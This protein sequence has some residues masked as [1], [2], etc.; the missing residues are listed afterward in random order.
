MDTVPIIGGTGALGFGMALRL[1]P[2]GVPVAIGSRDA[3]RAKE[4]AGRVSEQVPEAE[5]EGLDQVKAGQSYGFFCS[6]HQG[7]RGTL[8]VR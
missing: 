6:I 1:T 4:A 5:V 2:A 8:V 7:M 3:G